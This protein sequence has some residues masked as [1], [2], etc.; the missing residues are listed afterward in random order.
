MGGPHAPSPLNTRPSRTW[1]VVAGVALALGIFVLGVLAGGHPQASG[2]DRLPDAARRALVGGQQQSV[3]TQVLDL[4]RSRYYRP[5]D[6][7]A[8]ERVSVDQMVARL[9]DPYTQ[10][11]DPGEL[12][13]LERD[14]EG[15]YTGVGIQLGRRG[16]RPVVTG[17][18]PG[19][20]AEKAG[21]RAG[22][23]LVSVDGATIA[24]KGADRVIGAIKGAEGTR[25]HMVLR[26]G[27][28]TLAL[29]LTRRAIR[30]PVIRQRNVKVDGKTIGYVAL[31][32]FID[33]SAADLKRAVHARLDA[34][35]TALVLDLRHDPGG[36]LN[37]AIGAASV[38]LPKGATVVT[39]QGEHSKRVTL[40]ATGGEIPR[41]VPLVVLV[42]RDSASA[43]E[44]LAGALGDDGRAT[45]A[46]ERTFGKA[47]VQTT[48]GLVGGGALKLTTARYLTP[49]GTDINHRGLSPTV[50]AV[51]RAGTP[52]DEGLQRALA[53]AAAAHPR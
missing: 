8:L 53:V 30:V 36:L 2:L 43:S 25:V 11:L 5:V 29:T 26:R 47:L 4:L 14:N 49:S 27:T 50:R 39:T 40:R 31:A 19:S 1:R 38:F 16:G 51:D 9:K 22:D 7:K 28:E 35:A 18:F 52:A 48:V 37:E 45:L 24:A 23:L 33:G 12:A 20:P 34:G 42:D 3:S 44:I 15:V 21:I 41:R 17:V 13:A 6:A 32:Q 46:G 10:Y